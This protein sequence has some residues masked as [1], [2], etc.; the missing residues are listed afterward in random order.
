MCDANPTPLTPISIMDSPYSAQKLPGN[1]LLDPWVMRPWC[2][3]PSPH[4]RQAAGRSWENQNNAHPLLSI[5]ING[6]VLTPKS[7]VFGAPVFIHLTPSFQGS[8]LSHFVFF[9]ISCENK[10]KVLLTRLLYI[11]RHTRIL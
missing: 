6:L 4:S 2:S 8:E 7:F 5:Y 10:I 9:K 3:H 1:P 11:S